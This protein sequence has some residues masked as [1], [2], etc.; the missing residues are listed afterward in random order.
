MI[1]DGLAYS[2]TRRQSVAGPQFRRAPLPVVENFGWVM[3]VCGAVVYFQIKNAAM[4][5]ENDLQPMC[6]AGDDVWFET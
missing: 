4:P 3:A 5:E 6:F 1:H 2:S